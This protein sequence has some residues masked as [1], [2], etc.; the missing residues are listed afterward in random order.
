MRKPVVISVFDQAVLSLFNL[1][2]NLALI[3]FAV[4]AEFGRFV[5][6]LTL[7]LVATSL[8]NAL[9]ATPISVM[10]P[11]RRESERR[12][13]LRTLVSFDLIL[14]CVCTVVAGILCL[15][16]DWSPAFL[17][18][19]LGAVFAT[20]ARET[21]RNIYVASNRVGYCLALDVVA[22]VGAGLSVLLVWGML[23]PATA[24]LL[25]LAAGNSL[26][27]ATV[28]RG[29]IPP[30]LRPS[31]VAARYRKFWSKTKWSLVGAATTELQ[32]RNY[33]FA[34]EYFRST[35]TL[36]A[37]QAG[38]LLLG[39][40]M[41][42]VQ[43]WA[44]VARPAMARALARGERSAALATFSQ[45]LLIATFVGASYCAALWLAWPWLEDMIYDG[46]Y[47]D[48][49]LTT[50]AWAIFTLAKIMDEVLSS[51][52]LA[53]NELRNLA[54]VSVGTALVTCALLFVL[55][56]DVP[57][58]WAVYVLVAGQGAAL[59]WLTVLVVR[60]FAGAGVARGIFSMGAA[61]GARR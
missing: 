19:V 39:P 4:P 21:A 44:R 50:V 34:V 47:P 26:A 31:V 7:I 30:R 51:L 15:L 28:A 43:S 16:T 2:I 12:N 56:F 29:L 41:L 10:L 46:K 48:I 5:F 24:C 53:A 27:L 1:G 6:A 3:K 23:A 11:G 55:A 58:V 33:V 61:N 42:F 38:R 14:R 36:G 35:A 18:A 45:G 25:G 22:V 8:Q 54:M 59:V 52:L 9:V 57:A 37:V 60:L 32:D 13:G 40:L 20:L 49:A 17:A